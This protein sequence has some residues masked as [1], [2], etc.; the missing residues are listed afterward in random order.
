MYLLLLASRYP[1]KK[2]IDGKLVEF[3]AGTVITSLEELSE[4]TEMSRASV[5]RVILKLISNETLVKRKIRK[6]TVVTI[7]NWEEYQENNQDQN[8]QV[9]L[10]W[11][12]TETQL[13]LNRSL[14]GERENIRKE[15][16]EEE[17]AASTVFVELWNTNR[18]KRI[19]EVYGLTP[20]R[21]R[22][23]REHLPSLKQ[24]ASQ[25]NMDLVSFFKALVVRMNQT[26][27]L[28]GVSGK[29]PVPTNFDTFF[30]KE[31][32]IRIVEGGYDRDRQRREDD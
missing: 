4:L 6:G 16:D 11:N 18:D 15:E 12:S 13:K 32:Y 26:A 29:T 2:L 3:P 21:E 7:C 22:L 20:K 17:K 25:Y 27:W 9:K 8:D 19:P 1:I 10:K 31:Q 28:L 30:A 24:L 14:N 5:H 23:I